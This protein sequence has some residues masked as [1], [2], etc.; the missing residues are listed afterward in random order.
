MISRRHLR[1][2]RIDRY[3]MGPL[4]ANAETADALR[5]GSLPG[6]ELKDNRVFVIVLH[7][8]KE[9]VIIRRWKN[10]SF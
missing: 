7:E 4:A 10:T 9:R 6:I 5:G 1:K 8:R 3:E 2:R